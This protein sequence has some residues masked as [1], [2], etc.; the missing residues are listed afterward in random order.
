ME[1]INNDNE[2]KFVSDIRRTTIL[3]GYIRCWGTPE[4]RIIG[5]KEN[6]EVE[7]YSFPSE[8]DKKVHRI[9]TVGISGMKSES[10]K[11]FG[12]EFLMVLPKNLGES[13]FELIAS[14]LLDLIA[15]CLKY[16]IEISEGKTISETPLMPNS[17]HPKALLFDQPWGEPEEIVSFHVGKQHIDL[18]WVIPIYQDEQELIKKEG[19]KKFDE[20]RNKSGWSL[21]DPKRPTCTSFD[22]I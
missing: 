21:A 5:Q 19:I 7:I 13:S 4:Y 17:W 3:G 20:L 11:A 8:V 15:Y 6:D 10:G 12:Y 2:K 16:D 18:F 14:F 9:A 1:R 22:S